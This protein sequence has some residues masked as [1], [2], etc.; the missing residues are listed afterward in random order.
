MSCSEAC[1]V[2]LAQ[3]RASLTLP[4]GRFHSPHHTRSLLRLLY[5]ISE[6]GWLVNNR[7]AFLA[8]LEAESP[9]SVCQCVQCLPRARCLA[10][11]G[12][13]F[14][15]SPY[16]EGVRELSGVPSVRPLTP[17]MRA[18]LTHLVASQSLIKIPSLW[19]SAFTM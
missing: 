19:A 3:K 15:G 10:H 18:P 2:Q 8:L 9:R 5:Q 16:G 17:F 12:H 4:R 14:V 13:L 6:A 11:G 7:N 1:V